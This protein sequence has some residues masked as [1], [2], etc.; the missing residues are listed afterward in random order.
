[1]VDGVED[2]GVGSQER[3]VLE[4]EVLGEVEDELPGDRSG[5][6]V[7]PVGDVLLDRDRRGTSPGRR[8]GGARSEDVVGAED[9]RARAPAIRR[10]HDPTPTTTTAAA[11]SPTRAP[12]PRTRPRPGRRS[13]DAPRTRPIPSAADA[14][15]RDAGGRGAAGSR[16]RRRARRAGRPSSPNSSVCGAMSSVL[17]TATSRPK[18]TRPTR[19]AGTVLGSVIM[20]NRK[21]RTSGEVTITRQ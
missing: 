5:D 7:V 19:P 18:T 20:K 17:A 4:L 21:I 13:P 12:T 2:R 1:M 11:T 10:R 8:R 16:R 15:R 6:L 9:E 14:R 3:L